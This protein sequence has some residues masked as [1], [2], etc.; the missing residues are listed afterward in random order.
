ML[1]LERGDLLLHGDDLRRDFRQLCA[2]HDHQRDHCGQ[3]H[4]AAQRAERDLFALTADRRSLFLHLPLRGTH[5]FLA[6]TLV[7]TLVFTLAAQPALALFVGGIVSE[8]AIDSS[9]V[10]AV[11]HV[12]LSAAGHGDLLSFAYFRL[13]S[14]LFRDA[15]LGA[16]GTGI[17]CEFFFARNDGLSCDELDLWL[18]S[19]HAHRKF[20]RADAALCKLL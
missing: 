18:S 10:A 11:F 17:L 1:V 15:Q 12:L 19:A 14:A 16:A 2:A 9:A 13:L 4:K 6:L 8:I 5:E 3:R 7:L 20:W